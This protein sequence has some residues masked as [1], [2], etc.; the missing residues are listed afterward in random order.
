MSTPMRMQDKSD[1]RRELLFLLDVAVG[2]SAHA[3]ATAGALVRGVRLVAAPVARVALRP[4]IVSPP[5]QPATWLDG[6]AR[7]GGLRRD[8]LERALAAVLDLVVPAVA[9]ELVRRLDLVEIVERYVDLDR[10]I[11]QVDLDS[12]VSRVDL[13]A[14]VGRVDLDAVASR[15]DVE[16]V[17]TR[18][19]LNEIVRRHV[20]L[21]G[22]VATVD[23]DAAAAR[24][25]IE[26]VINR[27]DV[28][29][30]ATD[31]I[32]EID[33]PEI[34][35]E[36]TGSMASDTL[37]EIRMQSISG[38]DAI[39]RVVDRLRLRRARPVPMA[40]QITGTTTNDAAPAPADTADVQ[41]ARLVLPADHDAGE[42]GPKTDGAA[43]TP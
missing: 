28:V 16:A 20:D 17:L 1:A 18:L 9:D 25:D 7:R 33:L 36:S 8:E 3:V 10:I 13:D 38:D 22:L 27:V 34:I 31:V 6:V 41:P 37:R 39:G 23:L 12:A 32:A 35:R 2:V 21:D 11:S 40:Q 29:G 43:R 5:L 4:P 42:Q 30:I 24:L 26:A 19:D 14:V 15:L